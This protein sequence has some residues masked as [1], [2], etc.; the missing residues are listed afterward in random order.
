MLETSTPSL[1]SFDTAVIASSP[2][3][4]LSNLPSSWRTRYAPSGRIHSVPRASVSSCNI[5][6]FGAVVMEVKET[7]LKLKPSKRTRPLSVPIQRYPSAVCAMLLTAPPGKLLS[8][9]HCSRTY[10][11]GRRFGSSARASVTRLASTIPITVDRV[12]FK[13]QVTGGT[14]ICRLWPHSRF[15]EGFCLDEIYTR[16]C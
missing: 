14:R 12:C 4:T 5:E 9:V 8:V 2:Y 6:T 16:R 7:G 1:L 11:E 15:S 10:W 3:L 13:Q